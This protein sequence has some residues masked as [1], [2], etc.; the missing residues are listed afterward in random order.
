GGWTL[1]GKSFFR[2]GLPFTVIDN[3]SLA[4]LLGLNYNGYI[5]ASPA[6]RLPDSCTSAVNSP[7]LNTSQFAPA[8]ALAGFGTIGRNSISGPH[9][10]DLDMALMKDVRLTEHVALSFGAQAYNLF[11]HSNFDEP[12]SDIADPQFGR[13]IA[14]VGPPTSLLGSFVG[15]GSSPRF[16]EIKGLVRF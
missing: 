5:L 13:S 12:V 2:T 14:S 15:A 11:N 4:P 9:F 7:C 6:G 8:G 3:A 10:F 1:S 16:V